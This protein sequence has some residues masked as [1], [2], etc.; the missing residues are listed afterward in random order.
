MKRSIATVLALLLMLTALT[1]CG[2]PE[3]PAEPAA[4]VAETTEPAAAVPAESL[5]EAETE[6]EPSQE[7][8]QDSE[9]LE[10]EEDSADAEEPELEAE[11]LTW[12]VPIE[13]PLTDEP[14]SISFWYSGFPNFDFD[15]VFGQNPAI[16]LAEEMTGVHADLTIVT[17]DSYAEKFN[18]M[19][20][21]GEYPDLISTGDY[22]G[23]YAQAANDEIIIDI[24]AEVEQY[25]KNY[26]A[27]ISQDQI[28]LKSAYSDDSRIYGFAS[29]QKD[30]ALPG[31]GPIIRKDWLVDLGI[32]EPETYAEYEAMLIRFR[33]DKGAAE[34]FVLN[35]TGVDSILI[36]GMDTQAGFYVVDGT[37]T[38]GY[39]SD[40]MLEYVT[41]IRHWHENGLVDQSFPANPL[42]QPDEATILSDD[43]GCWTSGYQFTDYESRAVDPSYTLIGTLFPVRE[44]GGVVHTS[45]QPVI[46]DAHS[47]FSVTVDCEDPVL[48]VKWLDFWYS[49][50][51][52][53]LA[54]YGIEGMTYDLVDGKPQMTE[55][56]TNN[57]DG[58]DVR[59][60]IMYYTVQLNTPYYKDSSNLNSAYTERELNA[61]EVWASNQDGSYVIPSAVAF[62]SDEADRYNLHYTDVD[63]YADENLLKFMM[64][65]RD[66]SEWAEYV[67]VFDSLGIRECVDAYQTAYDRFISR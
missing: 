2:S 67:A 65:D 39:T 37:V 17:M 54:N 30:A 3:T 21:T 15:T 45:Y 4:S 34:P 44:K 20:A 42:G 49:E 63:T 56:M 61:R 55:L 11:P 35:G 29:I 47:L 46:L 27:L 52:Y 10:G 33:D 36:A 41:M 58:L 24:T 53:Y 66:L 43:T 5:P 16:A 13:L 25:A 23:G 9:A 50:E 7:V 31:S 64:G 32:E 6:P 51:G 59:A 8:T 19:I 22:V 1:A 14:K 38:A 12:P 18:L 60:C 28:T 57:P 26:M 62:N 48:A 40:E